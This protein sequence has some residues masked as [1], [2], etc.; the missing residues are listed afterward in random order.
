MNEKLDVGLKNLLMN[1]SKQ[2]ISIFN[3]FTGSKKVVKWENIDVYP[4]YH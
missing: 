4:L 1:S 3:S 2:L